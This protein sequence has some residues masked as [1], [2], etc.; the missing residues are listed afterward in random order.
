MFVVGVQIL[1]SWSDSAEALQTAIGKFDREGSKL[2][3]LFC[4][5]ARN[6][7]YSTLPQVCVCLLLLRF[8][9]CN[10]CAAEQVSGS[11]SNTN[12]KQQLITDL[13]TT[14]KCTLC[15]IFS[16]LVLPSLSFSF[17]PFLSLARLRA[18]TL[19]LRWCSQR[20]RA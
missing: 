9:K 11:S 6:P 10:V 17:C 5:A 1:I 2:L 18:P 8:V 4:T 13:S 12:T 14:T 7:L 20:A 16:A 15:Y 19:T 3:R